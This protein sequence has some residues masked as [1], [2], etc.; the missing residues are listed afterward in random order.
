MDL[1]HYNQVCI[2]S[3]VQSVSHSVSEASGPSSTPWQLERFDVL[4]LFGQQVVVVSCKRAQRENVMKIS[5]YLIY[6]ISLMNA[7]LRPTHLNQDLTN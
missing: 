7:N 2:V 5:A 1:T 3:F 4:C 6:F